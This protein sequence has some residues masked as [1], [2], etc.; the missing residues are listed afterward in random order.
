MALADVVID[1]IRA[2]PGH[3]RSRALADVIVDR[4]RAAH[5]RRTT[6]AAVLVGLLVAALALSGP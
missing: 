5:P 6:T 2:A 4:A 3:G 1:K